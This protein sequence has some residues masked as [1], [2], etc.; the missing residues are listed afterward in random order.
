[1]DD[2]KKRLG[3][4]ATSGLAPE[5]YDAALRDFAAAKARIETLEARLE[6]AD[7]LAE[8]VEQMDCSDW[9]NNPDKCNG[10]CAD[11]RAYRKVQEGGG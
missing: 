9:C 10:K 5:C 7:R 4:W 6:A 2:L 1:M 3:I 8:Y 11:L